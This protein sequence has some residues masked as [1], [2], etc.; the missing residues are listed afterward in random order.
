VRAILQYVELG[1]VVRDLSQAGVLML[2]D[3]GKLLKDWHG[4]KLNTP[5]IFKVL[6]GEQSQ[7]DSFIRWRVEDPAVVCSGTWDDASVVESWISFYRS[8]QDKKGFCMVAGEVTELAIQHP[9]KLRNSG[10]KAKLI[11]SNDTSGFTF[12]GKFLEAYEAA[13]VG[14]EATQKAHNALRWLIGRQGYRSGTQA[15]V[16]W[17]IGGQ[18]VPNPLL[19]TLELFGLGAEADESKPIPLDVAQEFSL[20]LGKTLAGY[21]QRIEFSDS[22]IAMGLDSATPG[23]M[24]ITYYR[25]FRGFEFFERVEQWH[26]SHAWLQHFG[27]EA[28]FCGAPSPRDIAEGAYGKNADD[29]LKRTTVERLIPCILDG[30]RIPYDLVVSAC[31]RASQGANLD[32][33]D[34]EKTLGIACAIFRGHHKE[35]KYKM[36][37]ENDRASRDY[38]YGRLLA[39]ADNLESYA[40]SSNGEKRETTAARMMQRFADR[41]ASTWRTISLALRPYISR[42]KAGER[43]AGFLFVRERLIDE[44]TNQFVGSDFMDDSRL[45]GEFLLGFHCQR[46]AFRKSEVDSAEEQIAEVVKK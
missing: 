10:D 8:N 33:W 3:K 1:T 35:R 42:L 4:E 34:W 30:R 28:R 46:Q 13:G 31:R 12:R 9:S 40:L 37:L 27:K 21:R 20:R 32:W 29:K 45:S 11:S 38:L 41:P 6:S 5:A 23:R 19:N 7:G 15:F 43:T 25:E 22:I 2:D 17:A 36:S 39:V 18:S 26:S 44:V 14:F 24:G 16:A